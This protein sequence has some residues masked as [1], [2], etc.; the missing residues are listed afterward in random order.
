IWAEVQGDFSQE[1]EFR[2]LLYWARVLA[3]STDIDIAAKRLEQAFLSRSNFHARLGNNDP[4]LQ[5]ITGQ[6]EIPEVE[7]RLETFLDEAVDTATEF[8][9]EVIDEAGVS[10]ADFLRLSGANNIE[11][12][13]QGLTFTTSAFIKEAA[14]DGD[15]TIQIPYYELVSRQ[16]G[17][18]ER[19]VVHEVGAILGFDDTTN[20][21]MEQLFDTW[22]LSGSVVVSPAFGTTFASQLGTVSIDRHRSGYDSQQS[23]IFRD[24]FSGETELDGPF[25]QGTT[26][27]ALLNRPAFLDL[28]DGHYYSARDYQEWSDNYSNNLQAVDFVRSQAAQ[29]K[30]DYS[31]NVDRYTRDL[32]RRS[33][34]SQDLERAPFD[35]QEVFENAFGSRVQELTWQAAKYNDALAE[36]IDILNRNNLNGKDGRDGEDNGITF[37]QAAHNF[38]T[39]YQQH[40]G[41]QPHLDSVFRLFLRFPNNPNVYLNLSDGH[42]SPEDLYI[43]GDPQYGLIYDD[44]G[45]LRD[46]DDNGTGGEVSDYAES[47]KAFEA[48]YNFNEAYQGYS[49]NTQGIDIIFELF[50]HPD[51]PSVFLYLADNSLDLEDLDILFYFDPTANAGYGLLYNG[52]GQLRDGNEFDPPGSVSDYDL[53][54]KFF[55]LSYNFDQAYQQYR[56]QNPGSIFKI[57]SIFELYVRIPEGT[58]SLNLSDGIDLDD[59][60]IM[61]YYDGDTVPPQG[62]G[63]LYGLDGLPRDNDGNNIGGE[64]ADYFL[65]MVF[66]VAAFNYNEA[67]Q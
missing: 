14:N 41:S 59:L 29:V 12:Y 25:K 17:E 57:D 61:G 64:I 37:I 66:Y 19:A 42:L 52:N 2:S 50:R 10:G 46:N 26:G 62:Y 20:L 11:D 47:M 30:Y 60:Y 8:M 31:G 51:D 54:M 27:R 39:A 32:L 1:K 16:D 5:Y 34:L 67:Y 38:L 48:A 58:P 21:E 63:F 13:I 56:Q 3:A 22:Q 45:D 36:L 49:G 44:N 28:F 6:E 55:E 18:L 43:L 35:V 15:Q 23:D 53:S 9:D 65:S 24:P 33:D 40:P 7:G 4:L